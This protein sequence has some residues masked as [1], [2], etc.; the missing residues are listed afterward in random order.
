MI[1]DQFLCQCITC[2]NDDLFSLGKNSTKWK[3]MM[4]ITT[5]IGCGT[6]KSIKLSCDKEN[7]FI[8]AVTAAYVKY[9]N[10]FIK[11]DKIDINTLQSIINIPIQDCNKLKAILNPQKPIKHNKTTTQDN[12][13]H[14]EDDS[15]P[16][17]YLGSNFW[18]SLFSSIMSNEQNIVDDCEL[19][20][21]YPNSN[22]ITEIWNISEHNVAKV[23]RNIS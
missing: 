21:S 1:V 10:T 15:A 7:Q 12:T 8:L 23:S 5:L 20:N 9:S 16:N 19:F 14:I 17:L 4:E 13:T 11:L 2:S 6:E 22:S 18:K 3:K